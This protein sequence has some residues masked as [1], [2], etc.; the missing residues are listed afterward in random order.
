MFVVEYRPVVV[1]RDIPALPPAMRSRIREAIE[2]RLTVD[3]V[4]FGK[5]LQYSLKGHRRIR[6]GDYRVVY[7][8]MADQ[9]RA[10][11]VAIAHRKDIYDILNKNSNR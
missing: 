8:I 1:K 4:S 5:P 9:R 7:R 3:P 6:V 11:I 10:V 2:S